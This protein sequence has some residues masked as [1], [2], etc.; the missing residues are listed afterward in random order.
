MAIKHKV[1]VTKRADFEMSDIAIYIAEQG[2]PETAQRYLKRLNDF[3]ESISFL[4]QKYPVCR[5]SQFAKRG[6]HCAVFE[7]NYIFVY[8][9]QPQS[10]SILRVIHGRLLF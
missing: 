3:A 1:V 4:P 9:I 8:K 2:Y 6:Y 10:I 5:F 7:D